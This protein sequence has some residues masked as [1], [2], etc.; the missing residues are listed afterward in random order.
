LRWLLGLA[1]VVV[2]IGTWTQ[3]VAVFWSFVHAVIVGVGFSVIANYDLIHEKL[4]DLKWI[5][6]KFDGWGVTRRS[7]SPSEWF[8]AFNKESRY[9][10]LHLEG[11]RRL[12]GWP[13]QW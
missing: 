6:K 13:E 1:S 11:D 3:E 8:S 4:R 2:T 10:V 7:S 12:Y 9:I 5:H